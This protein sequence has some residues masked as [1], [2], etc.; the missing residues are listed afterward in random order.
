VL[1][2][3]GNK[4]TLL[5]QSAACYYTEVKDGPLVCRHRTSVDVLFRSTARYACKNA[6]CIIMTGRVMTGQRDCWK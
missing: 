2:S 6:T 5:Q 1:I 3:T 4:H